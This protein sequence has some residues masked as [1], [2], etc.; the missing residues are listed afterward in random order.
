MVGDASV[1]EVGVLI[2]LLVGLGW[3]MITRYEGFPL[4]HIPMYSQ[5]MH[6][7]DVKAIRD[8][9]QLR[10]LAHRSQIRHYQKLIYSED[11][12]SSKWLVIRNAP[13][14]DVTDIFHTRVCRKN[15]FQQKAFYLI[16]D[17]VLADEEQDGVTR[18]AKRAALG[19]FVTNVGKD[20]VE[21]RVVDRAEDISVDLV[22]SSGFFCIKYL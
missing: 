18:A 21:C 14:R 22:M 11:L 5:P 7:Y 6:G 12:L 1:A 19:G 13:G 20:L 9:G 4:T 10:A 16:F 8:M 15:A 3:V 17:C 2:A